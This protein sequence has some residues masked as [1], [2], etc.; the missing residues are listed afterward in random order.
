LHSPVSFCPRCPSPPARNRCVAAEGDS[1]LALISKCGQPNLRDGY[2]APVYINGSI[3]PL[4]GQVAN[5]SV[6]CIYTEEWLYE[7]GSGE[8]PATVRIRDG[9]VQSITY[10]R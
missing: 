4:P 10:G 1:R 6:P 8:L 2:C 7:R 3:Y 5:A 9:K